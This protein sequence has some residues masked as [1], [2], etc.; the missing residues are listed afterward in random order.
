MTTHNNK[1]AEGKMLAQKFSKKTY[2][3]CDDSKLG[4]VLESKIA[5]FDDNIAIIINHNETNPQI[6]EIR[7]TYND[8]IMVV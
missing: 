3:L 2:F 5:D 6:T 4:I 8:K 7:N 1:E